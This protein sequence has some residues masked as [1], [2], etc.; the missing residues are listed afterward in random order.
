MLVGDLAD[1][2]FDDVFEG[3]NAGH[4]AVF[5]D[6]DGHLQPLVAQLDHERAN[7]HRLGN[8]GGVGHEGG[9]NDGHVSAALG[10]HGDRA[11]QGDQAEDVI[12]VIADDGESGVTG[13]VSEVQHVLGAVSLTEG[14]QTPAVGHNVGGAERA[15]ADCVDEQVGRGRVEGTFF[16]GVLDEG[17]QL[18]CGTRRRNLFLRLDAHAGEHPVRGATQ[19]PDDGAGDHGEGHLEGDDTHGGGHRVGQREVL[20]DKLA[21]EHREDVNE[22][23]GD[24]GR[25]AGGQAPGQPGCAEPSHQQVRQ[26]GLRRVAEQDRGQ[27][28]AHLGTRQLCG[29]GTGGAQD[30]CGSSVPLVRFL[31]KDGLV[32]SDK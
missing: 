22:R 1:D 10:G 32:H 6:D 30:G 18:G 11:A 12:G 2:F 16:D 20:G 4:A 3:D 25:D 15:H 8:G 24:E 14:V 21:K 9:G 17:R 28:D 7:R 31:V 23:G 29:Q 5:V 13:F 26:R 19:Y 27:R